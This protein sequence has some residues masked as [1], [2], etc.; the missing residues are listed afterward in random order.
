LLFEEHLPLLWWV[1]FSL[2]L[3]GV[4]LLAVGQREKQHKA[5]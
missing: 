3:I 1:G 4:A 2:I 5:D